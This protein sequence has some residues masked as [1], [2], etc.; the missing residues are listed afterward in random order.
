MKIKKKQKITNIADLVNIVS[1]GSD[2]YAWLDY[3]YLLEDEIKQLSKKI[4]IPLTIN[5]RVISTDDIKHAYEKHS[6]DACPLEWSDFI[7]VDIITKYYDSVKNGNK[8]THGLNT[9]IYE[10]IIG[11]KYFVVEEIRVGRNK[12]SFKTMYKQRIKKRK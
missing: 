2:I 1:S 3:Q 10:K 4:E 8:T 9:I 5:K 7:L 6:V 12:L 11:D